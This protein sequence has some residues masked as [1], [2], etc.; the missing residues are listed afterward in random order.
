[1]KRQI[2]ACLLGVVC[3]VGAVGYAQSGEATALMRATNEDRAQQGLGPLKWDPALARAAQRHAEWMIRQGALSHQ[4]A[5]EADLITRVGQQGAHFRVVAENLAVAP[6]PGAV[7]TEWMHSP[8]H[9]RN[10]LDARLNEIGIGLVRQGGNLWAVE[11][12]SAG[13]AA[14]GSSQIEHTIGQLL[15]ERGVRPGGDVA[16]A[17]Q[18]CAMEHGSAGAARPKFIMRWQGSDLSRLPDVLQQQIGT[19]R[20]RT[21]TV[22]AC[23]TGHGQPGFTTYR[24]AVLLF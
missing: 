11:D 1:M 3:A 20:F 12:F 10:I 13:V 18:T 8:P 14:I 9:R 23:D 16:A 19:G 15:S 17:R 4:Y 22:G 5:G 2:S 7:E 24:L 21:A 6:N